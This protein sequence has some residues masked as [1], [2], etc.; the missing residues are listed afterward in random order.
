MEIQGTA[1]Y[2]K[3]N[4]WHTTVDVL[5]ACAIKQA[6][7]N[8]FSTDLKQNYKFVKKRCGIL[9]GAAVMILSMK[10]YA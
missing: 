4:G 8:N 9:L 6:I 1:L 10:D 7:E 3:N 2:C 5:D